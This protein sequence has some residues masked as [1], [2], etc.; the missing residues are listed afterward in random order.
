M[1]KSKMGDHDQSQ[2][3]CASMPFMI[4]C[5]LLT[6]VSGSADP[7]QVIPSWQGGQQ[8][9]SALNFANKKTENGVDPRG[10]RR[11]SLETSSYSSLL[12]L[13]VTATDKTS[14]HFGAE[15]KLL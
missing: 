7:Y 13:H 6:D 3:N 8:A 10:N 2:Q 4:S 1:K 12:M 5:L 15:A 9:R 11:D 14:V